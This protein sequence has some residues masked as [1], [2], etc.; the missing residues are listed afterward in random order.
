MCRACACPVLACRQSKITFLPCLFF[1]DAKLRQGG[2]KGHKKTCIHYEK[3]CQAHFFISNAHFFASFRYICISRPEI[4]DEKH[5]GLKPLCQKNTQWQ[6]MLC[7]INHAVIYIIL[8]SRTFAYC[9]AELL[10]GIP[11]TSNLHLHAPLAAA[12][13]SPSKLGLCARLAQTFNLFL[14]K[15][16]AASFPSSCSLPSPPC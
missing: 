4:K 7:K 12:R 9:I 15:P 2:G 6:Q 3:C 10:H 8:Y 11:P 13:H 1:D 16:C 14:Y 5:A